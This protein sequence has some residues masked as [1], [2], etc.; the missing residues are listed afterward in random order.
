LPHHDRIVHSYLIPS[1]AS[2]QQ[3]PCQS[4]IKFKQRYIY[5]AERT[6]QVPPRHRVCIEKTF[7]ATKK[8]AAVSICAPWDTTPNCI[9]LSNLLVKRQ[10]YSNYDRFR[11]SQG[12]I[13]PEIDSLSSNASF[14]NTVGQI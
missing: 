8:P 2:L 10:N 14:G 1:S 6:V 4:W 13:S 12:A 7:S 3:D 9:Q 11:T 5:E